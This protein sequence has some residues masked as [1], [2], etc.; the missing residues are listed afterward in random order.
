MTRIGFGDRLDVFVAAVIADLALGFL[1]LGLEVDHQH[2]LRYA[3]LDGG[4]TDTG[5]VVHGCEH[6]I[7][8]LTQ[9]IIDTLDGLRNLPQNGIGKCY[10]IKYGHSADIGEGTGRVN[11]PNCRVAKGGGDQARFCRLAP[12]RRA[13]QCR[14]ACRPI[15]LKILYP[16]NTVPRT[17]PETFDWPIRRRYRA[18]TSV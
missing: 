11:I 15:R 16:A 6:I 13:N 2:A 3:D 14:R 10:Y 4:E 12:R 17:V 8:Q 18:G 1:V 7:E 9:F 5:R